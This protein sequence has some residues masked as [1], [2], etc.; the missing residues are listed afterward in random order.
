MYNSKELEK[1]SRIIDTF[2]VEEHIRI[3]KI[4]RDND[5]IHNISENNNGVFIN[6]EDLSDT[7]INKIQEYINYVLLKEED[8][9]DIENTKDKIKNDINT[10]HILNHVEN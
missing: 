9:R 7:T 6:M 4:I 8:I 3:L 10:F 1:M 2:N 5:S